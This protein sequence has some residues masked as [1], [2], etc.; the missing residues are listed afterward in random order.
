MVGRQ[1]LEVS[2]EGVA[3]VPFYLLNSLSTFISLVTLSE[4]L[5]SVGLDFLSSNIR[6]IERTYL[7][8]CADHTS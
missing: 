3:Q 1:T 2:E 4:M 6:V 8:S 5:N 7:V